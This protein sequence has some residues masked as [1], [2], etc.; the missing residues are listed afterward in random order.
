MISGVVMPDSAGSCVIMRPF[1]RGCSKSLGVLMVAASS[2]LTRLVLI[3]TSVRASVVSSPLL[4]GMNV[5]FWGVS[6]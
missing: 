1:H 6:V 2:S 3:H 5:Y 4:M